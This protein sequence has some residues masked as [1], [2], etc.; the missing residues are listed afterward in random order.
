ML[1]QE[2]A[3]TRGQGGGVQAEL[4]GELCSWV[5]LETWREVGWL[6]VL[7]CFLFSMDRSCFGHWFLGVRVLFGVRRDVRYSRISSGLL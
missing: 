2:G 7:F 4:E 3:E 1:A 6:G 5:A